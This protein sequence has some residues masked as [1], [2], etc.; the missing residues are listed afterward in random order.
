MTNEEI[1][2][3][4]QAAFKRCDA[5]SCPLTE[6]QK[7][8][9]LLQVV[10]QITGY[11]PNNISDNANPLDELTE[12]ERQAFLQ[13]VK[14]QEANNSSWKVPILNDWLHNS[15]SGQVQF[16]RE[17]YGI[18]WLTRLESYHFAKYCE[19]ETLKLKVGDRIEVCN[20]L[21]EWVQDDGP[22]SREWFT[23]VVIQ[24]KEIQNGTNSYTSCTVRF[25][26]GA[27]YEIQGMYEWNRYYW[28]WTGN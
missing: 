16:I 7:E 11:F 20:G 10:G 2:A 12:E 15:D 17:R 27:E 14:A 1:E 26:N 8:I 25:N 22:C 19:P 9:I 28:R 5:A 18:Q 21:W 23:C 3:A 6:Q 24:I 4:L 13:F